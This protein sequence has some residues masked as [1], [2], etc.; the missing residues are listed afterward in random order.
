MRRHISVSGIRHVYVCNYCDYTVPQAH[1]LREHEKLHSEQIIDS[2]NQDADDEGQI[3]GQGES[4]TKMQMIY[5]NDNDR[6]VCSAIEE[7]IFEKFAEKKDIS[8]LN[9]NSNSTKME[10]H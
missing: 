8:N 3:Q 5:Q 9:Y 1:F 10:I 7:Q 2:A 6:Y 4:S